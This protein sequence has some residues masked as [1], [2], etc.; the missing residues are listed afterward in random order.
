MSIPYMTN[1]YTDPLS[2]QAGAARQYNSTENYRVFSNNLEVKVRPKNDTTGKP[3]KIKLIENLNFSANY[4]PFKDD[5]RWSSINMTTSTRL[6]ENK[7]NIRFSSSFSPYALDSL[8]K[9]TNLYLLRE[10]RKVARLVRAGIDI[11]MSFRSTAGGKKQ[12]EEAEETEMTGRSPELFPEYEGYYSGDYVDFSVPWSLSI[13]YNWSYTKPGFDD[14]K[15]IIRTLRLT[16]DI[17]LTK[18]WKIGGNTGYDFEQKKIT[19]TNLNL[20]R[21]L[22]CWEMRFA[23][24]PFGPHRHYSFTIN[25]K[26]SILRDLKY[27]KKKNWYDYM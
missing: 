21:D 15:R 11:S 16:G 4:N 17:S 10:S 5:K 22:H 3:K 2:Q 19:V 6:F 7:I 9:E 24:V 26:S 20:H 14:S 25:A 8:G 13:K 23:I 27:D 1:T 12:G 18:K